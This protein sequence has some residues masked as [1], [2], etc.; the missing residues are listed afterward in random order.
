MA[1]A[2][3][4]CS[5]AACGLPSVL[6]RPK[7]GSRLCRACFLRAFEDDVLATIRRYDLFRAGERV[8]LAVSG[9][10]DS[11]VLAAVLTSLNHR[12]SLGLDLVLLSVDEGIRGYRDDSLDAVR[13]TAAA[14][15]DRP[16]LAIVSY[17]ELYGWS[18]DE[19]VGAI[20]RRNN[21]SFCGVFRRQALERGAAAVRADKVATGH[22][23]DD[24]AETVLMNL[25]RGDIARLGRCAAA[26]TGGGGEEGG[27]EGGFPAA[28]GPLPRVKPFLHCYEK[29]IVLYARHARLDYVS[30][31]CSYSPGAYRGF[32]R[33]F[34]KDLEALRSNVIGDILESAQGWRVAGSG[35]GG[36]A[37]RSMR[38]CERC[39]FASSGG[40][41]QA[42]LL[43]AGLAAGRP[44]LALTKEG[45][46]TGRAAR[47]DA[48]ALLPPAVGGA[49]GMVEVGDGAPIATPFSPASFAHLASPEGAITVMGFGSLMSATSA[50]ATFPASTFRLATCAGWSRI[51]NRASPKLLARG[52]CAPATGE[53]CGLAF[54]RT[55]GASARVAVMEVDAVTGLA[56]FLQREPYYDIRPLRYVDDAG[57]GGVALAC[58]ECASDSAADALWGAAAA[59]AWRA[60]A[61]GRVWHDGRT[62]DGAPL[63]PMPLVPEVAPWE[64]PH[65]PQRDWLYPSPTYL[66]LCW[67]AHRR[68]G[69]ED[70]LLDATL[71]AD[72]RTTLRAY[73][74]A[75]K[76]TRAWV[77]DARRHADRGSDT[78]TDLFEEEKAGEG[79]VEA[80]EA[81]CGGGTCGD[82]S[83][84]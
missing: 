69:L 27:G 74:E 32:A 45:G 43:L 11:T 59:A 5:S 36:G 3:S 6:R 72:R 30:T 49:R 4:P 35:G 66:R 78:H 58:C 25:L 73:L 12:A 71:L 57:R 24:V 28:G 7:D 23:A 63:P 50:L 80:E 13:R 2:R 60:G 20:G 14:H 15:P 70:H 9:G 79:A 33:E 51:F 47:R 34:L 41:C 83:R 26:I 81:G 21:C 62:P 37:E 46:E 55:P 17:K 29:E 67:L 52:A 38:A 82:C 40:L 1:T 76:A 75:N 65:L 31:E 68:A 39:G 77:C 19:I 48:V 16:Q 10:K 64:P 56:A 18:M 22:N 42:C 44:R 84:K 53:V 8:A 54:A 61:R